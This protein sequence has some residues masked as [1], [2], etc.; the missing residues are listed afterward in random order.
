MGDVVACDLNTEWK[1]GQTV[2]FEQVL[3]V[4]DEGEVKVGKPAL[5]GAKVTAEVVGHRKGKKEVVFR[6]KKRKNV[7]VKRG[8]RQGYTEVRITQI[9]A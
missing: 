3:L 1:E 6:F 9:D 4:S 8:H 7:R 5:P 2:L